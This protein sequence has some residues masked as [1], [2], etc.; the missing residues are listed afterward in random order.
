MSELKDLKLTVATLLQADSFISDSLIRVYPARI[1]PSDYHRE[2][3]VFS[4]GYVPPE[5]KGL[6]NKS[7]QAQYDI[8]IYWSLKYFKEPPNDIITIDGLADDVEAAIYRVLLDE[9]WNNTAWSK[10]TIPAPSIRP[11]TP[12]GIQNAQ[13]G[14]IVARIRV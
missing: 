8:G 13:Y 11:P 9:N 1:L 7:T 12:A 3:M 5:R 10:I 14:R 2:I 6:G 4:L